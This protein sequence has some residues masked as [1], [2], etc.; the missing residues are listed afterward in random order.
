MTSG[1]GRPSRGIVPRGGSPRRAAVWIALVAV[2]PAC[3]GKLMKV[4]L[5][6]ETA[7]TAAATAQ[8]QREAEQRI[9]AIETGSPRTAHTQ[10]PTTVVAQRQSTSAV[11]DAG[12][13]DLA[14]AFSGDSS[15]SGA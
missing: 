4:H 13:Y 5:P 10:T 7:A 1:N 12:G 6:S 8:S 2:L 15:L 11:R 9:A 3:G 14:N